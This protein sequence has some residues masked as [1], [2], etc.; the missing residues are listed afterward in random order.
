MDKD[1]K[2]RLKA[3]SEKDLEKISGGQLN[4][5]DTMVLAYFVGEFKKAGY[6]LE[7]TIEELTI[8][9]DKNST[10]YNDTAKLIRSIW[11]QF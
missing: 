9:M 11:N 1:I 10:I 2:E 6:S 4:G 8:D 7:Q 3:I 5:L